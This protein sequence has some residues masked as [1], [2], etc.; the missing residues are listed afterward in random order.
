MKLAQPILE[1][2]IR[3]VVKNGSNISLWNDNWTKLG[4]IHHLIQGPLQQQEEDISVR[5]ALIFFEDHNSFPLSFTFPDKILHRI[6]AVA[7]PSYH[8]GSDKLC[9][10]FSPF[11]IFS[12]S[13]A[14]SLALNIP[15]RVELSPNDWS[16]VWKLRCLPKLRFF[17]WECLHNILPTNSLLAY[18]VLSLLSWSIPKSSTS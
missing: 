6:I 15:S 18:R 17:L 8:R 3:W 7:T 9:W 13:S 16:W 2:G 12:L 5:E 11:G 14:Y 10:N 4:P 1:Q